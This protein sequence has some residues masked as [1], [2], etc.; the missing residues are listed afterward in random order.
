MK[1]SFL[2]TYRGKKSGFSDA[3][4]KNDN[5]VLSLCEYERIGM[6]YKLLAYSYG[7]QINMFLF[8]NEEGKLECVVRGI[9]RVTNLPK[10][11]W[12][13][14]DHEKITSVVFCE[15]KKED[16]E[17]ILSI[18]YKFIEDFYGY[19][20]RLL[21][22][23][24]RA[25]EIKNIEYSI[26]KEQ[27]IPLLEELKDSKKYQ[28]NEC[29]KPN[30]LILYFA[31]T[32][33]GDSSITGLIEFFEKQSITKV[34]KKVFYFDECTE[35]NIDKAIADFQFECENEDKPVFSKLGN[36]IKKTF[37]ETTEKLKSI[38]ID[39]AKDDENK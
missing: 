16:R 26:S 33:L 22:S 39:D 24:T 20:N 36:I 1:I 12:N 38:L 27:F 9:G 37:S 29:L 2:C 7:P 11:P 18:S 5:G 35:K 14:G 10:S 3:L 6:E 15:E 17:A 21:E 4:L 13:E 28:L 34:S 32:G 30:K 23:I 8:T 31:P 25:P 19:G